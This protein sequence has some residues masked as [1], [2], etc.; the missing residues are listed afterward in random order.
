VADEQQRPGWLPP[1]Y[2]T[3]PPQYPGPWASTFYGGY[4]EPDNTPAMTGFVMAVVSLGVLV[5]FFGVLAPLTLLTSIASVFVSR[6]GLKK[7][8]RGETTKNKSLARWGFWLGI[9]GA[10]LAMV[11]I[12]TWILVIV[13]SPDLFNDQPQPDSEPALVR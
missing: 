9:A 13:N 1:Q 3:P 5:L 7:V 2:G 4:R 6:A 10:V 12:A 11:A 8:T